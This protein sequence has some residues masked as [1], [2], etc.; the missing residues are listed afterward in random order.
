[1]GPLHWKLVVD[2]TDPHAQAAFW[3][4]ALRYR[5]EDHSALVRRLL[6]TGAVPDGVTTTVHEGTEDERL[7][8]R[9]LAA[10]RHPDEPYDEDTGA[11]LGHRILF[12][13][14][15]EAKTVKNR[16]HLDLHAEAGARDEEVARLVALGATVLHEVNE[17]SGSW[18][19]MAD[20]ERN[21][22]CVQ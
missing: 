18:V 13:R 15:P 20:P 12:Q 4:A 2:A 9:D 19:V 17:P 6:G 1:M 11:G 16:V 10:V 8:W 14:V 22:F 7:G 21:E 5:E 3:A